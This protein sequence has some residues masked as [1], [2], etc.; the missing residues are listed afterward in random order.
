MTTSEMRTSTI[1]FDGTGIRD[2]ENSLAKIGLNIEV[3]GQ[4]P[5]TDRNNVDTLDVDLRP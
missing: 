1:V 5:K 4:R 2:D 3:D